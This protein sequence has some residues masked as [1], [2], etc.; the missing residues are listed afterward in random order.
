MPYFPP[1]L[2]RDRTRPTTLALTLGAACLA[3]CSFDSSPLQPHALSTP[4]G[5]NDIGGNGATAATSGGGSGGNVPVGGTSGGTT[6][7]TGP[8]FHPGDAG[9]DA[10]TG[11]MHDAGADAGPD[12]GADTGAGGFCALAANAGLPCDDGAFCTEGETCSAGA[13]AGGTPRDC[14]TVADACSDGVCNEADDRCDPTPAREG[15]NCADGLICTNSTSCRGG[16]CAFAYCEPGKNC[17]LNACPQNCTCDTVCRDANTCRTGCNSN[18]ECTLDCTHANECRETCSMG[19]DCKVN[20]TGANACDVTCQG[21]S[22]CEID[23][24]DANN[25]GKNQ[26]SI[27]AECLLRCNGA[28]DCGFGDGCWSGMTVSCDG[29]IKVCGRMCP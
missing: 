5:G 17:M 29:G 24:T 3:A 19:S 22:A 9:T 15:Q 21:G 18:A 26:C 6:G 20:C 4:D 2:R 27:G 10:T 14:S 11:G 8:D 16:V 7:G 13:C 12:A 28:K 25:C 23:C 1:V